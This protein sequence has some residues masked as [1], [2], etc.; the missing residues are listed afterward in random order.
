MLSVISSVSDFSINLSLSMASALES[1]SISEVIIVDDCSNLN[2][3]MK[4]Q[5]ITKSNNKI[6]YYKNSKNVGKHLSLIKALE[7]SNSR[8]VVFLD[9]MDFLIPNAIDKLF[10]YTLTNNLD[11]AYGKI[12]KKKIMKFLAFNTLDIKNQAI[13]TVEMN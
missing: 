12:A 2:H 13:L 6:N 4:I 8:Y 7:K 1:K 10:D 11:L 5:K 9:S 3:S